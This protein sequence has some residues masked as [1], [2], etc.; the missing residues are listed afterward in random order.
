MIGLLFLLWV[1][2][3]AA[4]LVGL[5]R[6]IGGLE[7]VLLGVL[8]STSGYLLVRGEGIALATRLAGFVRH[9]RR[10]GE[11][12]PLPVAESLPRLIAGAIL[13]LPG[14]AKDALAVLV[15]VP[16]LKGMIVGRVQRF[17]A[18][19]HHAVLRERG[20]VD[21]EGEVLGPDDGDDHGNDPPPPGPSTP[22]RLP[23]PE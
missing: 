14:F 16:P 5:V 4:T 10:T 19:R 20:V 11:V 1:V 13:V 21:I 6:A 18:G 9:A 7:T 8:L 2:V 22:R 17:I 15:L 23:P 12:P 3:E